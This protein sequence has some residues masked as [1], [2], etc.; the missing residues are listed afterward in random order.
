MPGLSQ[1]YRQCTSHYT[2]AMSEPPS[3]G[4]RHSQKSEYI[5]SLSEVALGCSKTGNGLSSGSI[6]SVFRWFN[7]RHR[8]YFKVFLLLR[9]SDMNWR[10][11]PKILNWRQCN[12][13]GRTHRECVTWSRRELSIR[14]HCPSC[15]DKMT[16]K[17]FEF[18]FRNLQSHTTWHYHSKTFEIMSLSLSY[19]N[20][21]VH[22]HSPEN[23]HS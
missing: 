9:F 18:S 15:W 17:I 10:Q 6:L 16:L 4:T 19:S 22:G 11:H 1:T 20:I 23:N 3:L 12:S 21:S 13:E 8:N 2:D 14:W 5:D 7:Q